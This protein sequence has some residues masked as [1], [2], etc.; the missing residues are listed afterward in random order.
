MISFN[1][2][3]IIFGTQ[4]CFF[5]FNSSSI[6]TASDLLSRNYI[7]TKLHPIYAEWFSVKRKDDVVL[8]AVAHTYKK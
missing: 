2:F 6:L 5:R 8:Q 3:H 1:A 7:L 4:E